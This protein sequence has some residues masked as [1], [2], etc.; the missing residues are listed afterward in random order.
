MNYVGNMAADNAIRGNIS[1]HPDGRR[2]AECTSA[3]RAES[4]NSFRRRVQKQADARFALHEIALCAFELA[5][6]PGNCGSANDR[7][8]GIENGRYCHGNIDEAAVLSH[9]NRLDVFDTS[10]RS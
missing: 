2:I 8:I 3:V 5:D 7:S 9:A 10:A 6:V 1:E 4:H